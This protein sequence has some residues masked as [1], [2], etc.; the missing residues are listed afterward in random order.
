MAKLYTSDLHFLHKNIV[1]FTERGKAT[2]QEDHDEWLVDLWNSQVNRSDTVY[3]GG[4]FWYNS[5]DLEG[6]K[7]LLRKL[8]GQK[9]FI[10][11]NHD[12]RSVLKRSGQQWHDIKT[13]KIKG[14]PVVFCHYAFHT[15]PGQGSG[16]FHLHGHSHGSLKP[17]GRRLDIG[18]DNYYN[19]FG[20]FK[21]FTEDQ[22]YDILSVVD[23]ETP[24]HH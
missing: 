14:H 18:L 9:I 23:I 3:H 10:K 6:F 4:D 12:R 21:F 5:E 22:I 15:W 13:D 11:G 1:K 16:T 7:Y 19:L 17:Y 2:T 24:D 20:E 8:N